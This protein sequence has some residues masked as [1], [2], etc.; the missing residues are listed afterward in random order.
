LPRVEGGVD[1]NSGSPDDEGEDE[2]LAGATEGVIGGSGS[3][4][5]NRE[6]V[7]VVGEGAEDDVADWSKGGVAAA[8]RSSSSFSFLIL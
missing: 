6:C 7:D 5:G 3:S 2:A 4:A 8:P 1:E